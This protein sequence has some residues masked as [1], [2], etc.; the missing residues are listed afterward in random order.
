[1]L[2]ARGEPTWLGELQAWFI[3]NEWAQ[4]LAYLAIAAVLMWL[5]FTWMGKTG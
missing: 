5:F 2:L 1:M 3:V 4:H